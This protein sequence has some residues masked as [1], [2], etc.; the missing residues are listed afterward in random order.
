MA[1]DLN[2]VALVGRLTRDSEMRYS[3]NG[4]ALVRFSIA[5]NRGK[6]NADGRWEDEPNFFDCVYFGKSA[7]AVNAYLTKGRQ[8]S[9]QGE[10]R[11]SRWESDGQS[12]SRVEIFVNSLSL[13]SSGQQTGD[14][15]RQSQPVAQRPQNQYR[16]PAPAE[17]VSGPEDFQDDSIPF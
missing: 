5:V 1:S 6:R 11:Q 2:V 9:I 13:L 16:T 15:P 10:L 17:S 12:R 4:G 7:E 8:V 3:Q 14:S